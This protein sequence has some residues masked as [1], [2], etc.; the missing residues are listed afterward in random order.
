MTTNN[1]YANFAQSHEWGEMNRLLGH[2]VIFHKNILMIIK[3]AKR[4]RFM[5]I[6][7][8]PLIDFSDA[9][10]TKKTFS[11]ILKVAKTEKCVFIRFRP[12]LI[13][14]PENR[15]LLESL[16]A[17]ISPMHLAAEHTVIIDLTI[18]EED[19]LKNMRRQTR[20]EVRKADK[21]GIIVEK[22]HSE[23]IFHE[24]YQVQQETAARQHFVP[25]SEKELL[26]EHKAFG[27]N[28]VIYVART[29]EKEPIA[30][31][32][33]LKSGAEADYYEAASTDLNRKLSGAYALQWRIMRDLKEEGFLRYNLWGI[34]PDGAKN[35]RYSGVTTFKTGFGGEKISFVPAHD[36]IINK[37]KYYPDFAFETLRKKWRKL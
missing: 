23:Q 8:G 2:K 7:C 17:H 26:A 37:L 24:F 19:L 11:D 28:A 3:N 1:N 29:A 35:H 22:S 10:L 4:G 32:L 36:I 31:G 15:T 33:I 25:P 27:K 18:P 30:Y 21:Q 13:D 20:Y 12:Q 9:S 5:E 14:S 6:P 16:G 34:A